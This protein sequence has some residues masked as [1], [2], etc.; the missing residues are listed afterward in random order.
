MTSIEET[1]IDVVMGGFMD[2]QSPVCFGL[3]PSL[4]PSLKGIVRPTL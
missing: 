2:I 1:S 3:D 4:G